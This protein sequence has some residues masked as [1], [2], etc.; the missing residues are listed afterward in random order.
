[1]TFIKLTVARS[2][3]ES[4]YVNMDLV[5]GMVGRG[6]FTDMYEAGSSDVAYMVKE[7]P[8]EILEKLSGESLE[9]DLAVIIEKWCNGPEGF[10]I[11]TT[12]ILERIR[13]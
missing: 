1:M 6:D 7:T 13:R 4:M 10:D 12:R 8:G 9:T 3:D 11:L 5:Q 2:A